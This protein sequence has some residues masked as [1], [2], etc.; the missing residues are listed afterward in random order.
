MT[1]S[2]LSSI[3]NLFKK[4]E[5]FS[6][7]NIHHKALNY[8]FKTIVQIKQNLKISL[9]QKIE[10]ILEQ[11]YRICCYHFNEL[12]QYENTV[13]FIHEHDI[14]NSNLSFDWV[15]FYGIALLHLKK[16]QEYNQLIEKTKQM[17][18]NDGI[19]LVKEVLLSLEG[20]RYFLNKNYKEALNKHLLAGEN[21]EYSQSNRLYFYNISLIYYK[22][23]EYSKAISSLTTII[24]SC[25]KNFYNAYILLMKIYIKNKDMKSLEKKTDEIRYNFINQQKLDDINILLLLKYI[26][27][28]SIINKHKR[29][30][31]ISLDLSQLYSKAR[32]ILNDKNI[33]EKCSIK[34]IIKSY[35]TYIN[36]NSYIHNYELRDLFLYPKKVLNKGKKAIIYKGVLS[37]EDVAIKF[38]YF[39]KSLK[40]NLSQCKKQF[41]N[42]FNEITTMETVKHEYIL[43]LKTAFLLNN[44]QFVYIITPFCKGDS[45]YTILHHK[46]KDKIKISI[47][48]KLQLIVNIARIILVLHSN[49]IVHLTLTSKNFLFT[50]EFKDNNDKLILTNVKVKTPKTFQEELNMYSAPELYGNEPN[51]TSAADIYSFGFLMWEI[52]FEKIPFENMK[53]DEIIN[54]KKEGYC[55]PI[56]DTDAT[57]EFKSLSQELISIIM[58]CL[59]LDINE[60]PNLEDLV[61]FLSNKK[62]K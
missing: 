6:L 34:T 49:G 46:P 62:L 17:P 28:L 14:E 4:A 1:S 51:M 15:Y 10:E 37:N 29:L 53:E 36:I 42:V 35:K 19:N 21:K 61:D 22:L 12:G 27:S 58:Q 30:V 44:N 18:S 2:S 41:E 55:P 43:K 60:R 20:E 33:S 8:Y 32:D 39:D 31:Y 48:T 9:T 23:K 56:D 57:K 16:E 11:S 45:L 47:Q 7:K 25:D 3:N 50:K 52:L 5:D 26:E 24:N 59:E 38:Y 54:L 40:G 13:N